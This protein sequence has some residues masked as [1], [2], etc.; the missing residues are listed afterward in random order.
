MKDPAHHADEVVQELASK[1]F[2][3]HPEPLPPQLGRELLGV[4]RRH[5][6]R[7]GLTGAEHADDAFSRGMLDAYNYLK[8]HKDQAS[9]IKA[10]KQPR[11]W[12]HRVCRNATIHYARSLRP[13]DGPVLT[14]LLEGEEVLDLSSPVASDEQVLHQL[15][16]AIE[17][18]PPRFGQFI[19]LDMVEQLAPEEIQ[20]KLQI[21]YGYFRKLKCL[22][23]AALRQALLDQQI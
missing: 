6:R 13:K 19:R 18:L 8:R 17:K 9:A 10:I 21:T 16:Q 4:T 1:F 11:G 7:A 12:L 23:F 15:R 20:V 22:A 3:K 5:L 2:A 14:P